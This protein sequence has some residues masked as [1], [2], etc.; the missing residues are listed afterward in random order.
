MK[1][2]NGR[3]KSRVRCRHQRHAAEEAGPSEP[4]ELAMP[5]RWVALTAADYEDREDDCYIFADA[6]KE[7]EYCKQTEKIVTGMYM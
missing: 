6:V 1:Q 7:T 5:R 3:K 2:R 4:S